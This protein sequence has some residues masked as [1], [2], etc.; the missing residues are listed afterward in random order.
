MWE[1]QQFKNVYRDLEKLKSEI[2]YAAVENGQEFNFL[3]EGIKTV[4]ESLELYSKSK[5]ENDDIKN[6]DHELNF[7]S[8]ELRCKII[9][10]DIGGHWCGY[11]EVPKNYIGCEK[12]YLDNQVAERYNVYGGITYSGLIIWDKENVIWCIGF[13]CAHW[14]DYSSIN[15]NGHYWNL[16]EVFAETERLAKQIKESK[17]KNIKL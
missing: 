5:K 8:S 13:D 10:Q 4:K 7:I 9:Q 16:Q 14:N 15:R 1:M 12:K 2:E 17:I 3:L 6:K 11:V